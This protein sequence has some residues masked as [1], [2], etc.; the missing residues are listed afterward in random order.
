[1]LPCIDFSSEHR[2]KPPRSFHDAPI[3][4]SLMGLT[5]HMQQMALWSSEYVLEQQSHTAHLCSVLQAYGISCFSD[6]KISVGLTSIPCSP[7]VWIC[8]VGLG[9]SFIF[10]FSRSSIAGLSL[11]IQGCS[12]LAQCKVS[13]L[14]VVYFLLFTFILTSDLLCLPSFH[15]LC[16][17]FAILLAIPFVDLLLYIFKF[18]VFT[19]WQIQR[20]IFYFKN[21]I[22]RLKASKCLSPAQNYLLNSRTTASCW[23]YPFGQTS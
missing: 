9:S 8:L 10:I 2:D 23:V 20:H 1:M 5:N 6:A 14:P 19:I 17:Y 12:F 7:C 4:N 16:S 15:F 13:L 22:Y 21:I 11:L 3:A 18:Q